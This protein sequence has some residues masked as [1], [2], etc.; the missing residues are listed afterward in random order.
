MFSWFTWDYYVPVLF[1]FVLL[2]LLFLVLCQEIGWEEVSE[3]TYF[4]SM[5][6]K[7]LT[8]SI[9]HCCTEKFNKVINYVVRSKKKIE[10]F[11]TCSWL[12]LLRKSYSLKAYCFLD[13]VKF[14]VICYSSD[15][16]N[17]TAEYVMQC[18]L[19]VCTLLLCAF[20][21]PQWG[22]LY[23]VACASVLFVLSWSTCNAAIMPCCGNVFSLPRNVKLLFLC[24]CLSDSGLECA[25][26]THVV[27][28]M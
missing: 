6:C 10:Q 24:Y 25:C 9:N 26:I 2:D 28:M 20:C 23:L 1:A 17:N 13:V 5:G 19:D 18:M 14:N 12:C 21:L 4:V 22:G 16:V 11:F 8:Q 27:M 7:T 3:M 15:S